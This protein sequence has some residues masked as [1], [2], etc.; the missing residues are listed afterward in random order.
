LQPDN[1]KTGMYEALKPLPVEQLRSKAG[2]RMASSAYL[3]ASVIL[4]TG[5]RKTGRSQNIPLHWP[6]YVTYIN[7]FMD[8]FAQLKEEDD[9]KKVTSLDVSNNAFDKER[10]NMSAS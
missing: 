1:S 6:G 4:T 2:L 7:G 3:K 8:M 10:I 5:W 9:E